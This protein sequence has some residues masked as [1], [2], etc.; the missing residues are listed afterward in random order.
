MLIQAWPL[1]RLF[2]ISTRRW[3]T[4]LLTTLMEFDGGGKYA[5]A[6][7]RFWN[8]SHEA[9]SAN[10]NLF[11]GSEGHLVIGG[12]T[13]YQFFFGRKNE[14]GTSGEA[15]TRHYQ[16]FIKAVRSR[17]TSDQNGPVETAHSGTALAHLGNITYK[18]GAVVLVAGY[19]RYRQF[20]ARIL[21]RPAGAADDGDR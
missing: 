16:N 14:P 8:S 10:G 2:G 13:K 18:R 15:P 1:A 3:R 12:Y 11:Y 4:E 21:T 20:R 9:E 5:E 17:K 19:A 7:V 6:A